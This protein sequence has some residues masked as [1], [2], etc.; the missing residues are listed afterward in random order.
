[1]RLISRDEVIALLVYDRDNGRFI[2]RKYQKPVG[3][4]DRHGYLR[5][6]INGT[7]CAVHRLVWLMEHG[8]LPPI[9]DHAD[10]NILNNHISNLRASDKTTNAQN[11]KVRTDNSSGEKG[12]SWDRRCRKW[13][14]YVFVK[15]RRVFNAM[16]RDFNEAVRLVREARE[17]FHGEFCCHGD[18]P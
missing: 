8:S 4:M 14:A 18:T 2:S 17:K 16:T 11:S 3:F 9:V 10:R 6:I 13:H 15:D 12:V 1:M 5:V 7:N